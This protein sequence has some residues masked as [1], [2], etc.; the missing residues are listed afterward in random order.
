VSDIFPDDKTDGEKHRLRVHA[1]NKDVDMVPIE[2]DTLSLLNALVT[3]SAETRKHL[4]TDLLFVSFR[5]GRHEILS[6]NSHLNHDLRAMVRR[7]GYTT[8]PD[9]LRMP[10][11]RTTL[12]TRLTRDINNRD[13]VRRIMRHKWAATTQKFY[14]AQEKLVSAGRIAHALRPEAL[15]LTV[16]CQRP[17]IDLNERPD[18]VDILGRNPDNAELDYG[19]CGL[20]VE[21]Q[22]ACRRAKHCF[23]CPLLVPW[24]SKRHNFVNERDEYLRRA[25]EAVNERDRE[26]RLYHANQAEAYIILIDRQ[27]KKKEESHYGSDPTPRRRRRPRGAGPAVP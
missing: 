11:G 5:H 18:Q 24:A 16:A 7:H 15:R 14:R 4:E 22:G 19:H 26:N 6:T 27:L 3:H 10:D 1:P 9:D 21:R 12:G 20:D 2:T 25:E 8:L 13:K 17:I 23:E